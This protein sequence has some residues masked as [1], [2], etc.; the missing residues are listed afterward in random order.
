MCSTLKPGI[1]VLFITII[2]N[3][4]SN[5]IIFLNKSACHGIGVPTGSNVTISKGDTSMDMYKSQE[6][7]NKFCN[8]MNHLFDINDIFLP[9]EPT[10]ITHNKHSEPWNKGKFLGEEWS[11]VRKQQKHTPEQ[12]QKVVNHLNKLRFTL[13]TEDRAKKI[14]E[15]LKGKPLTSERKLNIAKS[16]TGT[17]L[18]QETKDKIATSL[19][20]KKRGSYKKKHAT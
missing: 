9:F 7:W 16:K 3:I 19:R 17:K 4:N 14:S 2:V 15:S 8:R 13:Y 18:S 6:D 10:I 5:I 11:D 12:Y 20:G 1:P